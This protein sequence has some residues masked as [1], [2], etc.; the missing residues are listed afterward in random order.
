MSTTMLFK[1]MKIGQLFY[2]YGDEVLNYDYPKI[3]LMLKRDEKSATELDDHW[4]NQCFGCST[5]MDEKDKFDLFDEK[6][7]ENIKE[8]D[9]IKKNIASLYARYLK[10]KT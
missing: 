10:L 2:C 6:D 5:L 4:E 8:H 9:L 3:C 1:N 7:I